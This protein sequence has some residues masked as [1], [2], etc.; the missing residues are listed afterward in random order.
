LDGEGYHDFQKGMAVCTKTVLDTFDED[1]VYH[2]NFLVNITALCDCWGFSTPNIVPDIGVMSSCDMVAVERACI[3]AIKVEN[4]L[5]GGVPTEQGLQG[6]GHLFERLHARN[7][8]LQLEELSL[9]GLGTQDYV[10]NEV[11]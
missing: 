2:I 1:C 9:L 6:E 10:L 5:M 3:D 11:K 4:V 7:P 8:Y